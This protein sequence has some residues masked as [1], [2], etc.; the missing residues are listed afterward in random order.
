MAGRRRL[1]REALQTLRRYRYREV[2]TPR[3]FELGGG[4]L[5][6]VGDLTPSPSSLGMAAFARSG[7]QE[8]T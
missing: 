5:E 2:I 1:Q 3:G 8:S 7:R 4:A 6:L